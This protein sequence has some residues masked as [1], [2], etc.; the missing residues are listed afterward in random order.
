V[1]YRFLIDTYATERLKVV[2]VWSFFHDTDLATRP[3]PTDNRG[4]SVLEQ[5]IHQCVSEGNWFKNFLAIDV[6]APPLP[7]TQDR[8]S[9]ITRYWQD[10]GQRLEALQLKDE[11]F[12]EQEVSF[13]DTPRSRAWIL[14]RR[15]AHTAHHRGQQMAM[16]RMLNREIRSNYGPT[17][18]TGDKVVY[19]YPD[20]DTLLANLK[21]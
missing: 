12:W 6:G 15:V 17:A 5:F 13:F 8:R 4:R 20:I 9:F 3:H 11:A 10:S 16:L 14:V 19:A 18:D 21:D 2:S 7:E 1:R